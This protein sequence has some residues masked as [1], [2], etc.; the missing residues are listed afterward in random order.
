M[1]PKSLRIRLALFAACLLCLIQVALSTLFYGVIS[2]WLYRQVDQS[3]RTTAVQ[4]S[5]TLNSADP[6][7]PDNLN[8]QFSP[9]NRATDAFLREQAFFIRVIDQ[10]TGN[11]LDE[12]AAYPFPVTTAARSAAPQFETLLSA[13]INAQPI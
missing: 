1:R 7:G 11:V 12:S 10:Q 8:F 9:G 13:D 6:L 2:D 4:V 5:G 3:L